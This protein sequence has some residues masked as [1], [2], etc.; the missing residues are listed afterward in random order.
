MCSEA[1]HQ[2]W[3]EASFGSVRAIRALWLCFFFGI[4]T[5][6]QPLQNPCTVPLPRPFWRLR[7][8]S[9]HL[10]LEECPRRLCS[11][12]LKDALA[13]AN[14]FLSLSLPKAPWAPG[15]QGCVRIP[16]PMKL[17]LLRQCDLFF[18]FYLF[19]RNDFRERGR[20]KK[21][22][23]DLFYYLCIHWVNLVCAQPRIEPWGIRMML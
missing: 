22:N 18:L 12:W 14:F 1:R 3:Q 9:H 20:Q 23:N 4:L 10:L 7:L 8:R 19:K 16:L 15:L 21:R 13:T 2:G 6:W 5:A 17:L 11:T